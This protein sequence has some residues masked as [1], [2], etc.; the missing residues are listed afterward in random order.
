MNSSDPAAAKRPKRIPPTPGRVLATI[1]VIFVCVFLFLRIAIVEPFGVPTGSMAP[2]LVGNHREAACPRCGYPVRVGTPSAGGERPG[3]YSEVPCPNCGKRTNLSEA[4]DINGDRLL[5]DK[6]VFSLRSP[7]RWEVAVFRCPY[8]L[9]KPYVKRTI[10]LPGEELV[11]LDGDVFTDGELLRKSLVEV[12]ETHIPVFDMAFSPGAGGWAPRWLV[13]PPDRDP[14]LPR[15]TTHDPAPAD[16]SVLQNGSLVL[17]G[18]GS[19]QQEVR[20]EYRNWNLDE[21]K[22]DVV[23]ARATFTRSTTST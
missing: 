22:E 14:R 16:D 4:R 18:S 7:R 15:D 11:I 21:D 3:Y 17:D 13:Y 9:S 19:P 6:N 20:L 5:V 8:D 12:R 2:A 10:G 1:S 23:A